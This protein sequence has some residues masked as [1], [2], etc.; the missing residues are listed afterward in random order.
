MNNYYTLRLLAETLNRRLAGWEL[1]DVI[2]HRKHLIE[3]RFHRDSTSALW[4]FSMIPD[5]C[6][7]FPAA[8]RDRPNRN[9][10]R[11]FQDLEGA[12]LLSAAI[13]DADRFLTLTF[14]NRD[15]LIIQAYGVRSN[16]L[17]IRDGIVVGAFR[18]AGRL[19]GSPA[20]LPS[21]APRPE[22]LLPKQVPMQ[23]AGQLLSDPRPAW[24]DG[25]GFTIASEDWLPGVRSRT[26]AD[27]GE[28]VADSFWRILNETRLDARRG[29][30]MAMLRR[31][32]SGLSVTEAQLANEPVRESRAAQ[33]EHLGRLLT[34]YAHLRPDPGAGS[35]RLNDWTANGDEVDVVVQPDRTLVESA[36]WYFRKAKEAR[37][38]AARSVGRLQEV[39]NQIQALNEAA[40]TLESLSRAADLD[41]WT[42]R[43]ADVLRRMG[44]GTDGDET[45]RTPYRRFDIAGFEV[46]VGKNAQMNDELLRLARK[47]DVWM[48]ARGSAGSHVVVR[49]RRRGE[50]IPKPVAE[51]AASLAAWYSKQKG[52]SL[53]P[54]IL[55]LRKH[56]RKPKGA[57]PGAVLVDR[58]DVLLVKPSLPFG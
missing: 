50:A 13:A 12:R 49:I 6:A 26:Y 38:S 34:A 20:P 39:R 17:H 53:V 27:V 51:Q 7:L 8:Y 9:S 56:V 22:I 14:D 45:V 41:L 21:P 54:V 47:D 2:T 44:M 10:L 43:Y 5:A 4:L 29:S 57:P 32:I 18:K 46:W 23:A 55:T 11:F 36:Q 15:A 42:K 48:H 40:A 16:V 25:Y 37:E 24:L 3:F 58:E 1:A 19:E 30:L 52:S 33:Y 28:G 35:I 31:R